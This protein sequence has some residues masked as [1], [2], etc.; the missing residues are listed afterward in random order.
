VSGSFAVGS[1]RLGGRVVGLVVA[2]AAWLLMVGGGSAWG[3]T[4]HA[5]VG[6]F[7]GL[8]ASYGQFGEFGAGPSGVSVIPATDEVVTLDRGQGEVSSAPRVQRFSA[9]GV[10]ASAF[11]I[12]PQFN[13]LG[14]VA[15]DSAGAVYVPTNRDPVISSVQKYSA[16]GV[17]EYELD[18]S[19]SDTSVNNPLFLPARV[20]VDPVDGTVYVA[21]TQNTTGFP[22]IDRFNGA[23]GAFIDSFDGSSNSPD[24]VGFACL[25][26]L[27]VDGSHR[28]YVLDGCPALGMGKN[29]VDRY[30]ADGVFQATVDDG[31]RG[32]PE[33]VAADPVSDEVYVAEKDTTAGL[34]ITHFSAGGDSVIYT[35]DAANA[36]DVKASA[37]SHVGTVYTSDAG[38]P[39][40]ERF[41]RFAGPTVV[42]GGVSSLEARSVVL[43]GT[44]NP[45]GV[46]ASYYF[47]YGTDLTYGKRTPAL[48]NTDAGDG[49]V[50]VAAAAMLEG[51]EPNKTYHYRMVGVNASGPIFGADQSFMTATAPV[52]LDGVAPF[53]SAITPRS[54]TMHATVN[55]NNF[56]TGFSGTTS[57]YFEYGTT[58]AYGTTTLSATLCGG[59]LGGGPCGGSDRPVA[60]QLTGL[61]PSTTYHFRVVADNGTGGPQQGVDQA[62][63][64]APAA[65]A[66][67]SGVTT[68]RA[69]LTGTIDPHGVATSYH[70]NYGTTSSYGSSTPELDG[71]SGD[72]ER[73]VSREIQGLLADTTY[74]VQVVA[75]SA[76]GVVR[77][78]GDGL[79]RTAQ[80]PTA[81]VIGPTGVSTDA[82]TLAGDVNT[83]GSTGSYHF[84]V[85]SL[86]GPYRVSTPGRPVA[87]NESAERVSA[88]LTGLPAGERFAVQLTV[89]SNDTVGVSSVLKFATAPNPRV[90]PPA[91]DPPA[92]GCASPQ[93]HAYNPRP[94]RGQTIT[95]TGE[96]LGVGGNVIMAD[97][98]LEPLSW[99]SSGF[100]VIVPDDVAGTLALTVD[101]GHRSNTIAVRVAGE[102][103]NRFSIVGR[104]VVGSRA[105]VTVTVPGPGKL[106]TSPTATLRADKTT[107]KRAGRATIK[108]VLT[109]KAARALR[110]A[111][112]GRRT[113]RARLRF[114]P[115]GGQP[116]SKTVTITFK[117]GSRR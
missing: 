69:T 50:A 109:T 108:L 90:F 87:G 54:A 91:A 95:I 11:T 38:R 32:V 24:G 42:T 97:R 88:A 4:G 45:E 59:F 51:L 2:G 107:V 78:G 35:F 3:T 60:A 104:S 26:G 67:A 111:S 77:A 58:T 80:P 13:A 114:T 48:A 17:L 76:D 105:T 101:C 75:T 79:F 43:E 15:G 85:W 62:F 29:R 83:M 66:G 36:E 46:E 18:A 8:G 96:D 33:S 57:Y 10:F 68:R 40:V 55:A 12:D 23:T 116:A 65:G 103:D 81:E 93:L 27:A 106:E 5:F 70:F 94:K 74:H 25:N 64:T 102:P 28:V 71:G 30:G 52:T 7:G 47:E 34:Q 92:Y 37:V 41:A 14:H 72:V 22:V 82:A 53:A 99:S 6:E 84:D 73:L 20:A 56:P 39:F 89:A 63:V 1:G 31:I 115:V 19:G 21:A 86:D 16:A 61:E 49:S 44:I 117:L 110:S 98:S 100:R 113:A 112:S 9:D